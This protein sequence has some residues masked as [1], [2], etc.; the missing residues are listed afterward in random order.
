MLTC[1]DFGSPPGCCSSCHE[2]DGYGSGYP[3]IE[4]SGEETGRG[5]GAWVCCSVAND[6]EEALK[7]GE[8]IGADGEW[9]KVTTT[10]G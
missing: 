4:L 7:R 3:L 5:D 6:L 1:I 10:T 8:T 2:D 9:V